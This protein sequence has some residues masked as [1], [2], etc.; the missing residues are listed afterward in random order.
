MILY[1]ENAK[2]S[3]KNNCFYMLSMNILK[4]KLRKHIYNGI[5][6]K[7]TYKNTLSKRCAS[8]LETTKH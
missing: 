5:T 4:M 8:V 3:I 7:K 6:Q 2:E 1:V